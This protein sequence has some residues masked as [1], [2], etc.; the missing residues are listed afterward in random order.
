MRRCGPNGSH[1]LPGR[2]WTLKKLRRWVGEKLN[3]MAART[4]L[5]AMLRSAGL[6]WK[7]CKKLL[8][9]RNPHKRA[10]FLEDFVGLVDES[11]FHRDL[12]S[13]GPGDRSANG[14]G[15]PDRLV[16]KAHATRKRRSNFHSS[17]TTGRAK[18]GRE[19]AVV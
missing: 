18:D 15:G 19:V 4:A 3:R 14:C 5:H 13:A 10:A 2:G 11:H 6:R 16:P 7:K 17:S 8:G 1:G 9:K 12:A